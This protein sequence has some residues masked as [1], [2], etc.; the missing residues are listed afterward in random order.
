MSGYKMISSDS[1]VV[2]P[3]DMWK[4]RIASEYK[5][6]APYLAREETTDQ[7]YADGVKFGIVVAGT[8]AGQRFDDPTK[9]TFEGR[10]EDSLKGGFDPHAHVI[11]MDADSIA[12]GVLYPSVALDAY[13][14]PDSGLLSAI[15]SAYND[16]LAEFCA[17]YPDRLKGITLLNVDEV[18]SAVE[19]LERCAK[20]GLVGAA[21]PIKPGGHRYDHPIYTP[22]W[23]AAQDLRM[24]LS[25]HTGTFRWNKE[26]GWQLKTQMAD[27]VEQTNREYHVRNAMGA[28]ILSGVFER[29]PKLRVGVVEFEIGWAPYFM[30]R[31]NDTYKDRPVG[32]TSYRFKEDMLPSDYFRRNV[33]ISF[34]EDDFGVAMRHYIGVENLMWGSDY[35]HPEST[36]PR[37]KEIVERIMEGVPDEEA[38]LIIRD[39]AAKLYGFG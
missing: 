17:P 24:P 4:E 10:Y 31:L 36:F 15:L 34:Q 2:E 8:L 25:L 32:Q 13:S 11:D 21:I 29:F 39:N 33:F 5:E 3:E 26:R 19:E 37:S 27:P 16:W 28:I 12:G 6:R 1:H 18:G 38:R 22:L 20:M 7:W 23:A 30:N 14:I 35:P 9:L